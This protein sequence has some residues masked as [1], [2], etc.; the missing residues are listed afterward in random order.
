MCRD[1]VLVFTAMSTRA[2][3]QICSVVLIALGASAFAQPR[4]APQSS[5][6]VMLS[7]SPVVKRVSPAVVNIYT[8]RVVT[9]NISPF[10]G[11]P[12]FDR[13]FGGRMGG[14]SRKQIENSLGSGVIVEADGLVIT[15]AHVIK[16]AQEITVALSDGREFNATVS[17]MDEPSDLAVLRM[18]TDGEKMPFVTLRPS[19]TLEVGD[20]VIAIGNPF[21]VGQTVTSGIV[22]ALARSSLN[23]ND[24]NFFIQTDAAINPGNSGGPLVAM[25]GK[26]VGINTAIFSRDGGSLGIGFAVPSEMVNTIIAAEKNGQMGDQGVI[27]PW[28]GITAQ[29]VTSDIADSLG[30]NRPYGVLI[31][32]LH[33]ESPLKKAGLKVGDVVVS[34]NGKQVRDPAE[35]RFRHATVPMGQDADLEY[36]REGKTRKATITSITPPESPAR[37]ERVLEGPHPL[38]GV[39]VSNLN[40][41]VAVEIG[42]TSHQSGVVVTATNPRSSSYRVVRPGDIIL[43]V[44]DDEIEDVK[45]LERE[46]K[47]GGRKGGWAMLIERGGRKTQIVIR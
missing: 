36:L 16:D 7:Y 44:N 41:A 15:N 39:Q 31:S 37:D 35:M 38:N 29:A 46:M 8:E 3:L 18:E 11:D 32:D 14:L 17:L 43:A 34:F 25:D 6:Q 33:D 23:I 21:G 9:R 27:R 2:I 30:L 13:F 22:S 1:P 42:I 10:M 5:E 45:D 20:I 12:F 26:V 19:E 4:E 28:M 40:P 47:Q 24:F